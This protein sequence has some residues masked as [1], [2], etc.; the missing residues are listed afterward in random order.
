M[1]IERTRWRGR[2]IGGSPGETRASRS[3]SRCFMRPV[4]WRAL[5][6][7]WLSGSR[8]HTAGQ[9]RRPSPGERHRHP[10]HPGPGRSCQPVEHRPLHAGPER[11]HPAYGEPAR[12]TDIGSYAA[13]LIRRQHVG[14]SGTGGCLPPPRRRLSPRAPAKRH[15]GAAPFLDTL[16]ALLYIQ[17]PVR[18]PAGA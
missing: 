4:V 13:R 17:A 9:L 2:G 1:G 7:A 15:D 5:R 18:V 14:R 12:P 16:G 8:S 10:H 6:P 3:M 11:V